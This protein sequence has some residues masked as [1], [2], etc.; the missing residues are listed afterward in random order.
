MCFHVYTQHAHCLIQ[1]PTMAATVTRLAED[2]FRGIRSNGNVQSSSGHCAKSKSKSALFFTSPFLP[3][4]FLST[5]IVLKIETRSK[6]WF[7]LNLFYY[8]FDLFIFLLFFFHLYFFPRAYLDKVQ[9]F[10]DA[11]VSI[12][13]S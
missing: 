4:R 11:I 5:M 9:Q 12:M 7:L 1:D 10:L 6:F 8:Y 2:I 3:M 13:L